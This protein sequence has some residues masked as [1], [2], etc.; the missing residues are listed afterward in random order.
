MANFNQSGDFAT[1]ECELSATPCKANRANP[2]CPIALEIRLDE[3]RNIGRELH[4]STAQ[5]LVAL[6]LNVGCLKAQV[7]RGSEGLR[8]LSE[9][10]S[11]LLELHREV[12]AVAAISPEA[13]FG[14]RGFI[15]AL[16]DMAANFSRTT[17]VR[18]SVDVEGKNASLP[19][20]VETA[21]YRIAQEAVANAARHG[22]ANRITIRIRFD[23]RGP[24]MVVEDNG[25]GIGL[26]NVAGIGLGSIRQRV[27]EIGGFLSI[28]RL[29][30]GTRIAVS[31]SAPNSGM[32]PRGIE[33]GWEV[34]AATIK[35]SE[36][37]P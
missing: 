23:L 13:L 18:V 33:G 7:S 35:D 30:R 16:F 19:S 25:I 24:I 14:G 3:R 27:H 12:R 28:Q 26:D 8:V 15:A 5:L 1:P 31:N 32:T 11:L 21:L 6:K 34:S 17:G 2:G 20:P 29:S 9:I 10:D 37:T 36:L 22:R 4:D